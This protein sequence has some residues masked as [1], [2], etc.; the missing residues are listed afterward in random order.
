MHDG[1]SY[2]VSDAILRHGGQAATVRDN[3]KLLSEDDQNKLIAF[4][5]SL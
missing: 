1:R 2:N 5:M 3:F 4:L